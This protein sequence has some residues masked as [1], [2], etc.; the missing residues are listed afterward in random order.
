MQ[1]Q[2]EREELQAPLSEI[3]M[4][5]LVDVMLVLLVIFLVTAPMLNSSI[6]L[7]L[8]SESAS[9]I[10]EQKPVTI[11]VNKSGTYFLNDRA[12]A[13]KELESELEIIAKQNPKQQIHL[14]ADI[15]ASYGQVSKVLAIS[16]RMGLSN[17]AFITEPK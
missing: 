8:P 1:S 4:T 2:F 15:D 12:V 16:Q 14:R 7:N 17:I 10:T 9:Q 3:N 5:P 6:K 11:S 13:A